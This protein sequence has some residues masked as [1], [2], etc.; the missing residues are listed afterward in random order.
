MDFYPFESTACC[1]E[2]HMARAFPHGRLPPNHIRLLRP[3]EWGFTMRS[4]DFANAPPY[5]AVS[6]VWGMGRAAD[7]VYVNEQ[8]FAVNTN[9]WSCLHYVALWKKADRPW[10]T[11]LWIWV[12]AVCIDQNDEQEKSRQVGMMEQIYSRAEEVIAWLGLQ[13]L[14]FRLQWREEWHEQGRQMRLRTAEVEDWSLSENLLD[15]A[16]RPNWTR[17]WIVQELLLAR[18]ILLLI[19]DVCFEFDYLAERVKQ[20]HAS[21]TADLDRVLAYVKARD[22]ESQLTAHSLLDRLREFGG[23]QCSDP[24]D[25]VFAMMSLVREDERRILDQCFPDYS[26]THEAV[27]VITLSF[28]RDHC[29]YDVASTSDDIFSSLAVIPSRLTRRRL[30][31]AANGFDTVSDLDRARHMIVLEIPR[32]DCELEGDR[33]QDETQTEPRRS[34]YGRARAIFWWIVSAAIA[35]RLVSRVRV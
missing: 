8:S 33:Q 10:D 18:R 29:D 23:C 32:F 21:E 11:W 17:T 20:G 26:L 9:L 1:I 16:E 3:T 15:I 28:L 4:F 5:T 27:V 24:R 19:S 12:D 35:W 25:K 2:G 34:S 6:Y 22:V 14:P 30:I 7:F 13:R 31:A